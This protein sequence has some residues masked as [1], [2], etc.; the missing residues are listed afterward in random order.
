MLNGTGL[1]SIGLSRFPQTAGSSAS[2]PIFARRPSPGT[3]AGQ[4]MGPP[5]RAAPSSSSAVPSAPLTSSAGPA[6]HTTNRAR[7]RGPRG[8]SQLPALAATPQGSAPARRAAI[9]RVAAA[10]DSPA[11]SEKCR[12]GR[13]KLPSRPVCRARRRF[14]APHRKWRLP[15]GGPHAAHSIGDQDKLCAFGLFC[16]ARTR[17]SG[18][19]PRQLP[20]RPALASG[21]AGPR[22]IEFGAVLRPLPAAL[23]RP[24]IR[25]H[26]AGAGP[27]VLARPR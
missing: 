25:R 16:L 20:A 15:T 22:A 17:C 11:S 26:F 19:L 24:A 4:T 8:H 27:R 12:A 1:A 10:V 18:R 13:R 9:D 23:A 6:R 2:L 21:R 7:L 5:V 14:A 3:V